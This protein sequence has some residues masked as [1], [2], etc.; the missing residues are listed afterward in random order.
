[1]NWAD[2]QVGRRVVCIG[3]TRENPPNVVLLDPI[4]MPVKGRVYTITRVRPGA[5]GGHL[6][7]GLEEIGEVRVRLLLNGRPCIGD[8]MYE[9]KYFRPLDE[10]RLDQFRKLLSPV[11]AD[12]VP[13]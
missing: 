13:A 7:L 5:I 4:P 8:V 3:E 11:P 2:Y 12:R 10:G 6:C 1:M 9:A